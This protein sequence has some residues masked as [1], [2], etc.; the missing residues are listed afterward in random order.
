MI[1]VSATITIS[2]TPDH[3]SGASVRRCGA[4]AV[5][6]RRV[7][8][9]TIAPDSVIAAALVRTSP[10][11]PIVVLDVTWITESGHVAQAASSPD[12]RIG[13]GPINASA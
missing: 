8:A 10:I 4:V 2:A 11:V 12:I 9:Y 1:S 3:S 7:S 5:R 6:Q 13:I